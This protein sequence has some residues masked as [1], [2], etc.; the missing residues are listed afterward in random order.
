MATTVAER[1][2]ADQSI[3]AEWDQA[4]SRSQVTFENDTGAEASFEPG[5]VCELSGSNM[6]PLSTEANAVAILLTRITDLANAGTIEAAFAVRGP[7]VID[8]DALDYNGVAAPATARTQLEGLSPPIV[9]SDES[10]QQNVGVG[11]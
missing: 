8:N 4:Y 10:T 9:L 5:L 6:V 2:F 11:A 3:I 1:K 7:I